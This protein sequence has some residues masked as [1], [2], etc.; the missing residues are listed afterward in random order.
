MTD[1][2]FIKESIGVVIDCTIFVI[3]IRVVVGI[4]IIIVVIHNIGMCGSIPNRNW[5][6]VMVVIQLILCAIP[7]K[8]KDGY[9]IV[10]GCLC[11]FVFLFFFHCGQ[12]FS[13]LSTSLGGSLLLLLVFIGAVGVSVVDSIK[14]GRESVALGT[15]E[16][17]SCRRT[18]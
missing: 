1:G 15:V 14:L 13:S 11:G 8:Y 16:K 10:K 17:I 7:Y 12:S 4:I 9:A 6:V 5:T 2:L 3:I 18:G